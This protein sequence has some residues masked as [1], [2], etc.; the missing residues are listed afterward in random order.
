MDIKKIYWLELNR[1]YLMTSIQRTMDEFQYHFSENA[2]KKPYKDSNVFVKLMGEIKDIIQ[3][4]PN[5][6][7]L[8]EQYH[9]SEFEKNILLVCAG[10]EL[11]SEYS[12][13]ICKL[14]GHPDAV[15]PTFNVLLAGFCST[16]WNAIS[17]TSPLR[18]WDLIHLSSGTLLANQPIK[19]DEGIL[20]YLTGFPF[21]EESLASIIKKDDGKYL[22]S[23]S[24]QKLVDNIVNQYSKNLQPQKIIELIGSDTND[25]MAVAKTACE[26][27][28]YTLYNLDKHA[29]PQKQEDVI[30]LE[31]LWNRQAILNHYAL[32]ID[33]SERKQD[34]QN[35]ENMLNHFIN[36]CEALTFINMDSSQKT[37]SNKT[38]RYEVEKPTQQEQKRLWI[39]LLNVGKKYSETITT[40]VEHFNLSTNTIKVA[41]NEINRTE[42]KTNYENLLWKTCCKF[43]RPV[44]ENLAQRIK[45]LATWDDIVLPPEE[46]RVLKE[47]T[48]HVRFRSKVY[49]EGG[50]AKKHSRGL[51]ISALFSGESGTGKTMAAEVI[52]NDLMLDLYRV[53][54][55]QVVNKYI[56][57]TEKNLKKIFDA[58]EEGGAILLFDEADSLFGKRGEVRDSHDR[59]SNLQI[60]YLLQRMENFNGLAILTTNMKNAIDKAFERRIR[61]SVHFERPDVTQRKRIWENAFPN[62]N[63]VNGVDYSKLAMANMPGGNIKN[64]AMNAA[65]LAA[66]EDVKIGMQHLLQAT[67]SEYKKVDKHL[68]NS[69]IK[70]WE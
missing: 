33:F 68:S 39:D 1:S 54:L 63:W 38:N 48:M 62:K 59:H 46:L 13:L 70:D 37:I 19:I 30:M 61:F 60:G 50:F 36:N 21:L 35:N 56:G 12:Q 23:K 27:L 25:K 7:I 8:V 55:S 34:Q 69:E 22:I 57:E 28:G 18:K 11:S 2:N 32:Y 58:A 10:I 20:H 44:L 9:L 4:K 53:D 43:T 64:I 40:L 66:S 5:L 47:I 51:G 29:I 16:H 52:A 31:K 41:A 24:Q 26:K 6:D 45:T 3:Q 17:P 42:I 65:F 14:Q 67:K 49:N 15:Y